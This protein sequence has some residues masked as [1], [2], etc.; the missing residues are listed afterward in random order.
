M[1]RRSA[2][3]VSSS[4]TPA[5]TADWIGDVRDGFNVMAGFNGGSNGN[6]LFPIAYFD[7]EP[8][9]FALILDNRT[10]QRW[11][12]SSDAFRIRVWG[13][14]F[15]LHVLTGDTLA[16]IRRQYMTLTGTPPIPP[17]SAFGLWISE[18]G[19][20]SWDELDDKIASLKAN[21][22]PLSGVVLDLFWFGGIRSNSP[23]SRM[24]SLR[25]DETRFPDPAGKIAALKADGID[26]MLIEESYISA[27]LPEYAALAERGGLAQERR[28]SAARSSTPPATGGAGAAWSTGPAPA[29]AISG[30]TSAASR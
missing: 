20:E 28:G 16:D 8:K 1:P 17:K 11:D 4:S 30:T 2:G 27:N 25:W 29:P 5:T 22:F 21:G 26:M 13:G 18:Y 15:R 3:W 7:A 14:D 23:D 12:F 10:Q 24:G 19:Y 6:T 9:P